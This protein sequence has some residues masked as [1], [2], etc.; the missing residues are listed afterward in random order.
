MNLE[1]V[2]DD[3]V[4]QVEPADHAKPLTPLAIRA[5]AVL[6]PSFLMAG[7]LEMLV[8]TFVDPADLHWLGGAELGMSNL[9]I[10]TLTFVVFWLVISVACV[11][12]QWL[13][14]ESN[15]TQAADAHRKQP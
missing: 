10:Y 8:F 9:A 2:D 11:L 4:P 12:T 15:Q 6:W 13:Q 5:S 14:I 7:V 1:M 3:V